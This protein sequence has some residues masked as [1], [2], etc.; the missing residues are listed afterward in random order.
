M[1]T[2]LLS[3]WNKW[4]RSPNTRLA[5]VGAA[6]FVV[7]SA[8]LVFFIGGL[9]LMQALSVEP[10]AWFK[11]VA[12]VSFV[13]LIFGQFVGFYGSVLVISFAICRAAFRRDQ[14][15]PPVA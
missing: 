9:G 3:L 12:A 13:A 11:P 4:G 6:L 1:I 8:M 14:G 2:H 7:P 15:V 10:P 5:G